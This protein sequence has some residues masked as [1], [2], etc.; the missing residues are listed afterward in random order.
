MLEGSDIDDFVGLMI[1]HNKIGGL[2]GCPGVAPSL[3]HRYTLNGP[4]DVGTLCTGRDPDFI[5]LTLGRA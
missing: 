5:D 3:S 2:S 1:S 4:P